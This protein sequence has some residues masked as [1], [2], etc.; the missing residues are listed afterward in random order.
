MLTRTRRGS[1]VADHPRRR[2]RVTRRGPPFPS[3]TVGT[4]PGQDLWGSALESGGRGCGSCHRAGSPAC[5]HL[6]ATQ[7]PHQALHPRSPWTLDPAHRGEVSGLILGYWGGGDNF[8]SLKKR[9]DR[10]GEKEE[11][12][13]APGAPGLRPPRTHRG[14][15]VLG[16]AC[17]KRIGPS[18]PGPPRTPR[19]RPRPHPHRA[20]LHARGPLAKAS[21]PPPGS[22]SR[23]HKVPGRAARPARLGACFPGCRG[24]THP[25]D[26]RLRPALRAA[27]LRPPPAA[28]PGAKG[29]GRGG[30]E[31]G[32]RE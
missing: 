16:G 27:R 9:A 18:I 6:P 11:H 2:P 8:Q 14:V 29:C 17:G 21:P 5:P 26:P 4:W 24:R 15:S 22:Q 32:R 1:S 20:C 28:G 12:N 31:G 3:P 10:D 13:R 23:A 7:H 30:A 25:S 19:P